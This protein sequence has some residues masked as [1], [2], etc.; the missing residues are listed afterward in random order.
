VPASGHSF[1]RSLVK[2][3]TFGGLAVT[4]LL[5]GFVLWDDLERV[6]DTI[7]ALAQS[8][9]QRAA[10]RL[11]ADLDSLAPAGRAAVEAMLDSFIA[12]RAQ[13]AVGHFVIAEIY[14]RNRNSVADSVTPGAEAI[15]KAIDAAGHRF[16][17]TS[18]W[19]AKHLIDGNL[20]IHV[21]VPL[22]TAAGGRQGWFEGGF[23]EPWPALVRTAASGL[24]SSALV[25]IAIVATTALLYPIIA[26]LS[27]GVVARSQAL[28]DANLGTL[29]ALG[30][31][32]AKRDSDTNSHN[33]RVALTAVRLAEAIG[34]AD[35]PVRALI[36]GAFL[37]DV[38]KLAIPDAILL[39]PGRLTAAEFDVMKTHVAHGL[40]IVER[41]DW[42]AD[43]APVIGCHHEKFDGSGYL[44]G[45]KGEA[46]PLIARI[47][48]IADV[49]DALTSPRPYKPALPL[50]QA[51][52][53]MAEGRGSHF[54]PALLDAFLALAPRLHAEIA[55]REDATLAD[56]LHAVIRT[57]FADT[58]TA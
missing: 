19:Y 47:F 18:V 54:D 8:E 43:A 32:I 36:K 4:L 41:L 13:G 35:D 23:L 51:V 24:R 38:G 28:L 29:E 16:D 14:D 7:V 15:D 48:A 26:S 12:E 46:I 55:G 56:D 20:V 44:K 3:L 1:K 31:A 30:G 11:P 45:T 50:D 22:L 34:L 9:A 5:G 21:T 25:L 10:P 6:D 58:A 27:A 42:L 37:H 57:A 2:R 53:I 39:K 52:A 49:F 40:D 17:R 33:Y